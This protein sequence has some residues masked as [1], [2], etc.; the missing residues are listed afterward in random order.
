MQPTKF[1]SLLSDIRGCVDAAERSDFLIDLAS[2]W[3]PVPE[4]IATRPYPEENRVPGCESEVF[5]F[6]SN[7]P[8]G[9]K[10]YFFAVENPH[11][12]AAKAV[13]VLLSS[14]LSGEKAEAI[15]QVDDQI[16]YDLFGQSV[17]MGRA[18]GLRSLIA[19]VK[20]LSTRE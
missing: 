5:A 19:T 6:A 1:I 4:V 15:Q 12:I 14:T 10:D 16:I 17:T 11:G 18:T 8:D 20:A 2:E 13:A 3:K 9:T 7:R